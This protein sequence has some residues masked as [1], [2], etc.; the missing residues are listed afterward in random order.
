[1]PSEGMS[2]API[3]AEIRDI[4]GNVADVAGTKQ[5]TIQRGRECVWGGG[6]GV[7]KQRQ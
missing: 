5:P 6:E 3:R 7:K 4:K 1:M 2:P